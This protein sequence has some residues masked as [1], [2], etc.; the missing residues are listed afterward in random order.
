MK[1]GFAI[2]CALG[3]ASLFGQ[4]AE[5]LFLRANKLYRE[6]EWQQALAVY[7]GIAHKGAAVW[8]NMGHCHDALHDEHNASVC[9]LRAVRDGTSAQRAAA[10]KQ[11]ENKNVGN[12]SFETGITSFLPIGIFQLLCIIFLY[13]LIAA[14]CS[15]NK[16]KISTLISVFCLI[17]LTLSGTFLAISYREKNQLYAI[18]RGPTS[19]FIGPNARY[20]LCCSLDGVQCITVE[21]CLDEWYRVRSGKQSGWVAS[22][23]VTIV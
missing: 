4:S 6:K 16:K 9:W 1:Y 17:G 3:A 5:E 13:A 14:L 7:D 20:S 8:Y 23:A 21:H 10:I 19:L 18:T 12:F 2:V 11:L 15:Q 22:D